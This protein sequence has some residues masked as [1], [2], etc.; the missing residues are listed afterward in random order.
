MTVL[1]MTDLEGIS[2]VDQWEQVHQHNWEGEELAF[3]RL[4]ADTNAAVEGAVRAGA[5]KIYVVDGHGSGKNFIPGLLDSRATQLSGP[6]FCDIFKREKID[7][8]LE[9]GLHAKPGTPGAFLEHVQSSASWFAFRIN[10][11][12]YGELA[13]GAL[14]AGAYNVP[15][16]MISGDNVVCQEARQC[17]GEKVACAEVKRGFSWKRAESIDWQE[18]EARIRDA[19]E[20][21]IRRRA[22]IEPF[23]L[24]LPLTIEVTFLR[25]DICEQVAQDRPD[26]ERVDSRTLRRVS[27]QIETYYDVLL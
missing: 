4:M 12:D 21:G 1:I 19:A 9:I 17:L 24:P 13:Q 20:D 15:F 25:A 18:A 16:V 22:E 23:R 8:Y 6:E 3:R 27:E 11:Q 2:G 26:L 14:F 10:G 7:A 5:D